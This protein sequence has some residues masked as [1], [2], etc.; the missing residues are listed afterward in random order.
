M[1][2]ALAPA[3]A[4]T[5]AA[6]PALTL[7]QKLALTGL[8][9]DA[10]LD[11]AGLKYD[12]RT[13]HIEI[14]EILVDPIPTST[15]ATQPVTVDEVLQEARRLIIDRG[16]CQRWLTNGVAMCAKGAI[17]IAAGGEGPLAD[18]AEAVLLDRI[19]A[20]QPDVLSV[21]AWNDAQ[22]GPAPVIR[23]LG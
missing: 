6:A 23:M 16:W 7:D 9:M 18:A 17:Q 5:R 19:R 8:A 15:P 12:I 10:H 20:E 21:G 22:S 2:T 4:P 11:G 3:A 13:A 14:P 1:K